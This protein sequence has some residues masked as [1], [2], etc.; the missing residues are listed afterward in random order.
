MKTDENGD[1]LGCTDSTSMN[2]DPWSSKLDISCM[3]N[4]DLNVDN[5]TSILDILFLV[6]QILGNT[7]FTA[8]QE[9]NANL[10]GDFAI[11]ILDIMVLVNIKN[12]APTT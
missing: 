8:E 10:N 11:D 5:Q 6:N 1:I 4:G 12:I 2:Y 3:P 7:T 9:Y